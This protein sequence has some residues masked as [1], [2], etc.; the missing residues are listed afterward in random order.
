MQNINSIIDGIS[1]F[2]N[3]H[4]EVRFA[5][6]LFVLSLIVQALLKGQISFEHALLIACVPLGLTAFGLC[7]GLGFWEAKQ[8][9]DSSRIRHEAGLMLLQAIVELR[10]H[11]EKAK[12]P[13]ASDDFDKVNDGEV[14]P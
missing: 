12:T 6:I 9:K 2:I 13:D 10:N 11:L 14:K 7:L 4:Q 5:I 8:D 1:R 3:N